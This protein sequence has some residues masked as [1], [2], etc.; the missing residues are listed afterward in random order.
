MNDDLPGGTRP[1]VGELYVA[2]DPSYPNKWHYAPAFLENPQKV[3]DYAIKT[4]KKYNV[5][6]AMWKN[7]E[8]ER[9]PHPDSYEGVTWN[10]GAFTVDQCK[11][12]DKQLRDAGFIVGG[13]IR[14]QLWTDSDPPHQV[15][16]DEETAFW[17]LAVKVSYAYHTF[18]WRAFY[19]DTPTANGV[20]LLPASVFRRL[21]DAFPDCYF[22][23]EFAGPGYDK[24]GDHVIPVLYM[25]SIRQNPPYRSWIFPYHTVAQP[26]LDK[27][28]FKTAVVRR[29]RQ[30]D[31]ISVN[32]TFDE[33]V[34]AKIDQLVKTAGK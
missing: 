15:G 10:T 20:N 11:S 1:I 23:P 25:A 33:D 21:L 30:G 29:I 32:L 4:G 28:L 2:G 26:F 24:L 14:P 7:R 17:A 12:W 16:V 9:R 27:A 34:N 19:V 13:L 22:F 18:G 5:R 8:G 31:L 3:V 6:F